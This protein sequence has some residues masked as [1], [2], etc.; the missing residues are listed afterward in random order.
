MA[1]RTY[2]VIAGDNCKFE[3]MTK[4]QILAAI[5]QAVSTGE[6][7]DVDTGFVTKLKE[8]NKGEQLSFWVGTTSEYNSIQTKELNCF[9]ILTDDTIKSE[10]LNDIADLQFSLNAISGVVA[11]L[12]STINAMPKLAAEP[13]KL[14]I[15]NP[16]TTMKSAAGAHKY[17]LFA[18]RCEFNKSPTGTYRT[19]TI[20]LYLNSEPTATIPATASAMFVM[21]SATS[22]YGLLTL[23]VLPNEISVDASCNNSSTQ[24]ISC[25]AVTGVM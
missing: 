21:D 17:K 2:Y 20:L 3:S 19:D 13:N 1:E 10:I 18:A 12:S 5:T 23:S 11:N 8:K 22:T 9:Y 16:T 15:E 7:K 14:L 6:I 24:G 25:V 4:E